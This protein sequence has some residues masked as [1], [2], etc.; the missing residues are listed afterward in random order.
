MGQ[1]AICPGALGDSRLQAFALLA[2]A[3]IG[4]LAWAIPVWA[5]ECSAIDDPTERLAC[6]DARSAERTAEQQEDV[7]SALEP[8]LASTR[9]AAYE[10]FAITPYRPNYL[11]PVTYS[12]ALGDLTLPSDPSAELDPVEIK[13]Q[14]SLQFDIARDLLGTGGDLY[15]AYT[16]VSYWQAYNGGASRPFRETNYEP[17]IGL[18][19]LTDFRV[20]GLHTRILRL[21]MVHQ[22]NGREDPISRSWNR[23]FA[24][25]V[26]ERGRFALVLRPWWRIPEPEDQ[27]DNPDIDEFLGYGEA[28]VFYR[29]GRQTLGAMVRN[30]LDTSENRG[31]IQVDWSYPLTNKLKGYVQYYNGY[32]E[33]L[34]D[35]DRRSTR[36][37]VGLMLTD[38][39]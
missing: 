6:Y 8:R 20:L 33:S 18:S 38:W 3:L 30:N 25:A 13:F 22:S 5:T 24:L 17:E 37:G 32:G 35:Y 7:Q 31:A 39:L 26:M 12:E 19:W 2:L 34:I 11:L 23:V 36:I 4:G 29:W 28:Y 14:V 27:D 21:G 10:P 9:R 1:G 15:A 16:Q